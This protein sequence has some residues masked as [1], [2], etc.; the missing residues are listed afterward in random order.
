MTLFY[1]MWLLREEV[2]GDMFHQTSYPHYNSWQGYLTVIRRLMS[3]LFEGP[4]RHLFSTVNKIW[5]E[6]L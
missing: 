6:Q 1:K 4:G 5:F 3:S 2:G